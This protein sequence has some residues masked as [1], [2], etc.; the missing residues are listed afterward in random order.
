M[1][2]IDEYLDLFQ[3]DNK[4]SKKGGTTKKQSIFDDDFQIDDKKTKKDSIFDFDFDSKKDTSKSD[5]DLEDDSIFPK[6]KKTKRESSFDFELD[7]L[8]KT[9]KK[10]KQDDLDGFTEAKPKRKR[11]NPFVFDDESQDKEVIDDTTIRRKPSRK[12]SD[13]NLDF[14]DNLPPNTRLENGNLVCNEGYVSDSDISTKGC[15][16]CT[17]T[18]HKQ[19][20]C[21]S[22]GE[23]VCNSGY[24]GDG[25]KKCTRLTLKITDVK[26]ENGI[27]TITTN[28]I[29]NGALTGYCSFDGV[30]SDA[31]SVENGII[32]CMIPNVGDTPS[33]VSVSVDG[34]LWS[35]NV[36]L[37]KKTSFLKIIFTVGIVVA[38]VTV[39][40]FVINKIRKRRNSRQPKKFIQNYQVKLN[41]KLGKPQENE[42][43]EFDVYFEQIPDDA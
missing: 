16:K 21:D 20:H 3:N 18:C 41:Q 1:K 24:Q 7:D 34:E 4:K 2:D 11:G 6:N 17:K 10:K 43:D 9:D 29:E 14:S 42:R 26:N 32:R 37:G 22:T 39:I 27:L 36:S 23:C 8:L 33:K 38:I 13:F 15:W 31:L 19:A 35:N 5:L 25:V 40:G 28:G 30:K 12:I